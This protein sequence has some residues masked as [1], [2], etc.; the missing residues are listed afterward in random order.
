MIAHAGHL[1]GHSRWTQL[2]SMA[3]MLIQCAPCPLNWTEARAVLTHSG[4]TV[5]GVFTFDG[6]GLVSRWVTHHTLPQQAG[7]QSVA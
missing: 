6:E 1:I 2:C 4:I 7:Q 5:S 3:G